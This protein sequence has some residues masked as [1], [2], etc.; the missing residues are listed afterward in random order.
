MPTLAP[1]S[2]GDPKSA[3][4]MTIDAVVSGRELRIR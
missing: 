3:K 2:G 1:S 4:C